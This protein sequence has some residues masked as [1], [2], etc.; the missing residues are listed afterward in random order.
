MLI[1]ALP[2]IQADFGSESE[3]TAWVMT[4]FFISSAVFTGLVGRFGDMF[5]QRRMYL[6]TL[7]FYGSG[8]LLGG[9][10]TSLSMVVISR[11]IM[12]AG[13]GMIPLAF[14]IARNQ[15]PQPRIGRAMGS[16]SMMI[17]FGAGV[18]MIIGGVM[19][20]QFDWRKIFYLSAVL[21]IV[22]FVLSV[23]TIPKSLL[24]L[25]VKIDGVGAILF[26]SG[27]VCLLSAIGRGS[28]WGWLD[29]RIIAL[30][31][32]GVGTLALFI[33]VEKRMPEPF[34]HVPTLFLRSVLFTNIAS[35]MM[36]AGQVAVSIQ[37]V[38]LA[39]LPLASGGLEASA[40]LAGLIIIPYSLAMML[41][42]QISGRVVMEFGGRTIFRTGATLATTGLVLL[43]VVPP[44]LSVLGT[45]AGLSGLGISMTLM[46][47]PFLI[48]HSV[49]RSKASEANGINAIAR[50]VGQAIGTQVAASMIGAT[51]TASGF[52]TADGY[53][54]VFALSA[55]GCF[56]AIVSGSMIPISKDL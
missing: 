8:A 43:A 3:T 29:V 13:A 21:S 24:K 25:D 54:V 19:V 11:V 35:L 40:S 38:Q 14:A 47:G 33:V 12:G 9:F 56:F 34:V 53:S 31:A 42:S 10:S 36:G 26:A 18:G 39:Q 27:L 4:G 23:I 49:I 5:G 46:A 1:P 45:L 7:S 37:V 22:V 48:S 52:P 32:T 30:C 51:A 55:V 50:S 6:A 15:L 44:S 16:I 17:G 41:G 20:D 2:A 28:S